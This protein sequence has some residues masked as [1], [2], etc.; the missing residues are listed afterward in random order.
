MRKGGVFFSD[1]F[2]LNF[3]PSLSLLKESFAFSLFAYPLVFLFA[4]M[5]IYAKL[6]VQV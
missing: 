3:C 6:C 5:V 1:N 4:W 2:P